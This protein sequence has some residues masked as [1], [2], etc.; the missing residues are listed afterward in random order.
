MP[1]LDSSTYALAHLRLDGRRW[2]EL[3]R[4]HGQIST[5]ASADGSSVFSMG[6]TTV[7]CTVAGPQELRRAGAGAGAQ[8]N[9]AKIDVDINV[10]AFSQTDRK[11]RIRNDKYASTRKRGEDEDRS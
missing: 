2:N 10:A 1:G 9:D 8:S 4:I 7:L 11:R 6:N 3:R 5:Q